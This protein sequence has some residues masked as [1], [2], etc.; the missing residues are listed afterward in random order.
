MGIRT[1]RIDHEQDLEHS[2]LEAARQVL[3]TDASI[4]SDPAELYARALS[5][6]VGR[7]LGQNLQTK[8]ML[9]AANALLVQSMSPEEIGRAYEYLRGFRFRLARNDEPELV[10]SVRSKRNHGLFYTPHQV[11]QFIVRTTL[12]ELHV[13]CPEDHLDLKI[14]DASV[15][16]GVFLVE[17][18]EQ[19]ANRVLIPGWSQVRSLKKRIDDIVDLAKDQFSTGASRGVL[20]EHTAVRMHILENCLYGVDLD[21]IAIAIARQAVLVKA[22]GNMQ[23]FPQVEIKIRVG[24]SLIGQGRG[25]PSSASKE[26]LDRCHAEAYFG[27]DM[28]DST[29]IAQWSRRKGVFHWPLEYREVFDR[30]RGGFDAVI[31]NPPYEIISVKESGI[32]ERIA[33][34]RYFRRTYQTCR[35]KINTY[36]LMLERGLNLLAPRGALGFILPATL[37]ADSTAEDLRR[38][39]LEES[40]ITH[41]V[42]IPEKARIF[43]KV[44]QALLVLVLRKRRRTSAV[45]PA[46][47]DGQ[48]SI[49]EKGEV[50]IPRTLMNGTGLRIPLLRSE[51]EKKLLELLSRHPPF[52]GT[53]KLPSVGRVHQGEI[54][55]TTHRKFITAEPTGFP[56]IRGEHVMAF[57]VAHPSS[58]PGRLD[59]IVRE[60]ARNCMASCRSPRGNWRKFQCNGASVAPSP[61]P[62]PRGRG[63]VI[64]SPL[65]LG[66]G[67]GEGSSMTEEIPACS[68]ARR[69]PWGQE[70]IVLG[71]VV[72]MGTS[73][74][75]KAAAVPAGVFLGDMTNFIADLAVPRNYLIGL[76]N[77]RILNWRLKITSTNNYISAAEIELLPIP[78]FCQGEVAPRALKV[79]QM[80][81]A[82]L[83]REENASFET[84]LEVLDN[85]FS[86]ELK[87]VREPLLVEIIQWLVQEILESGFARGTPNGTLTNLLDAL[88]LNLYGIEP[89]PG[90][91]R[92]L[93]SSQS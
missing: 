23:F 72:N 55:L 13:P 25:N 92:L 20:D 42:F 75:L 45:R 4:A 40:E 52:K 3:R 48:G 19:I 38:M 74:R 77:S 21:P 59:W 41:A 10:P 89:W 47:W 44:T 68:K 93:E 16:T 50:E 2:L 43:R 14:L 84:C 63:S 35:G 58:R 37:V 34:Q 9:S 86:G 6:L 12:D 83:M 31:G 82:P 51:V 76:L 91:M 15:G 36:R 61:R 11:V 81:L 54:N 78:R 5:D 67:Q 39:V 80:I 22:F 30:D 66:E 87:N 64:V 7:L 1:G 26:G 71:R 28:S 69:K 24:N 27:R 88:V 56:L 79:A 17:A 32:K 73:R 29:D 53:D 70:R 65:S 90:L 18:L 8:E 57:R 85:L 46:F 49:P 62:S 33:D 60:Y